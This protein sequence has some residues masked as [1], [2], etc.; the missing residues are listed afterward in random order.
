MCLEERKSALKCKHWYEAHQA[1]HK[2]VSVI[3]ETEQIAKSS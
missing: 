3:R 2:Q 1:C